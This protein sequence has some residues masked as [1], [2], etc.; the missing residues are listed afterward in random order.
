M[1]KG[2]RILE[3]TDSCLDEILPS[4]HNIT[5]EPIERPVVLVTGDNK[6]GKT[7]V[8]K[9]IH[10]AVQHAGFF[11]S[12]GKSKILEEFGL[13]SCLK[14]LRDAPK[15]VYRENVPLVEL[16]LSNQPLKKREEEYFG[17]HESH[18]VAFRLF[19]RHHPSFVFDE[20][21]LKRAENRNNWFVFNLEEGQ[22]LKDEI[23]RIGKTETPFNRWGYMA[24]DVTEQDTCSFFV[25][26]FYY[27]KYLHL[28]N[29]E[30]ERQIYEQ[31]DVTSN[32]RFKPG[33]THREHK[34]LAERV[35]SVNRAT[36][37][38]VKEFHDKQ[39]MKPFQGKD[40][41]LGEMGM[42]YGAEEQ[43]EGMWSGSYKDR[44]T[45]S[46]REVP[47]DSSLVLLLDEP[48]IA[49]DEKNKAEF[50]DK[51]TKM[52]RKY[53]PKLQVFVATN[54]DYLINGLSEKIPCGSI[55]TDKQPFVYS[56]S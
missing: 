36:F 40:W 31:T 50:A 42:E 2:M 16:D 3:N 25:P 39:R 1:I 37:E 46:I 5:E 44:D 17:L 22:A 38:V 13:D 14:K 11:N 27:L 56:E 53:G 20:K 54:D 15:I 30:S 47:S 52:V 7:L 9:M 33:E 21:E 41:S 19:K 10:T 18:L 8:L 4:G 26:Y 29:D 12:C 34:N 45:W 28:T 6:R 49:Y 24:L 35:K 55:D 32:F 23:N 51:I 43:E 48:T